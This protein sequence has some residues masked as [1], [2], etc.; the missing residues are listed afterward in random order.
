MSAKEIFLRRLAVSAVT[1]F[2]LMGTA[3]AADM[4]EEAIAERI[5]PVGSVYLEGE[6]PVETAAAAPSGPR[7]GDTIYNTFCMA[8]HAT[9]A[10]GAPKVGDAA[11]WEP[12]LAQGRDT[13][14]KHAIEGFNGMPARGTCMD[15]SDEEIIAAVDHLLSL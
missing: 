12:R 10:A 5:A 14:N 4:S 9:G 7:T 8:C 2:S 6:A 1:A 3:H 13:L 11:A 15:C